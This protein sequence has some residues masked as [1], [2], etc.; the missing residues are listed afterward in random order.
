MYRVRT[1]VRSASLFKPSSSRARGYAT[2]TQTSTAQRAPGTIEDIF[3]SFH[4]RPPFPERFAD[5]KRSMWNDQ[6]VESW[7]EVIGELE[8]V[9]ERVGQLG[10]AAVPE[11]PYASLE[12]GLTHDESQVLKDSGAFIVKGAVSQQEAL[13]WRK[14]LYAHIMDNRSRI[15]GVCGFLQSRFPTDTT[16]QVAL[17]ETSCFMSC[18]TRPRKLLRA[19]IRRLLT[20]SVPP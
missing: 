14:E 8:H 17:P 16:I 20:R 4:D 3:S 5:L 6:L 7:R 19:R 11:I 18:T 12:R 9:T 2:E 13:E 1:L 15:K 10:S